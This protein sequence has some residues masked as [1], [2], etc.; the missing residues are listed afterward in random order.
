MHD[1]YVHLPGGLGRLHEGD[2][3]EVGGDGKVGAARC[4]QVYLQLAAAPRSHLGISLWP[5]RLG[6][7]LPPSLPTRPPPARPITGMMHT[8]SRPLSPIPG[9]WLLPHPPPPREPASWCT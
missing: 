9:D 8:H 4:T 2:V 5:C 6:A 3:P 7:Y 1:V